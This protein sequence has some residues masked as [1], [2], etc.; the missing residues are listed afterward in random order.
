V[1]PES[2][3]GADASPL[4]SLRDDLMDGD[5]Q[6]LLP[7][8]RRGQG[9]R[10]LEVTEMASID[11]ASAVAIVALADGR[12]VLVPAVRDGGV[13]RRAVPGD[14]LGVAVLSAPPPLSVELLGSLPVV[15]PSAERLVGADMSNEVVIVDEQVVVKWQFVTAPGSLAGP[16]LVAHLAA[17]GFTQ[18]PTPLATVAW[19]DRLVASAARYL[20]EASDGWD[21]MVDDLLAH[22]REGEPA[23][24]WPWEV[25]ALAGRLHAA[26]A[27]PS[28]VIPEP[29]SR[30]ADLGPLAEHY[31]ALLARIPDLDD[32]AR[33]AL[34]AWRPRLAEAV[35]V[36]AS[37]RDAVVIP[38][39]GDL[40]A[41]QFLRWSGGLV[42]SDFDGNPLLPMERRGDRCPAAFDLACLL[43][44]LDH[45]AH[46]V[47]R[48]CR[49][50]GDDA[51]ADRALVWSAEARG[52]ALDGYLA[53]GDTA[54]LDR[55]LLAA[56]ESLS[57]LHELVYA[58][59]YLPRWSYVPLGVLA[60]GW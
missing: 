24:R 38:V 34:E 31:L 35:D 21:W 47:A 14:G 50:A 49:E 5:G 26:C 60:R 29:V 22:V 53:T 17:V 28:A 43:R 40:H 54:L 27:T 3:G 52:D 10:P 25:G 1:T 45:V 18:M 7:A 32:D 12:S 39:H 33:E 19:G 56:F 20:P 2:P 51:G 48:R 23:P 41:G 55:E 11:E 8:L 42:V 44:S 57:P 13:W 58:A 4:A 59:D 30:A 9:L 16:R 37:S 36:L 6:A 46:V 15:D